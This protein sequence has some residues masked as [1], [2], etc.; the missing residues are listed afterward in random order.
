MFG[1]MGVAAGSDHRVVTE[2]FLHFEQADARFDQ[3]GGIAVA[4][5]MRRNSFFKP[6]CSVT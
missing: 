5:A 1:E 6:I 2:N 3:V 4:K